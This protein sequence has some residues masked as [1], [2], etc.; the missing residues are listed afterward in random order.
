M[1]RDVSLDVYRHGYMETSW[2][3]AQ[4]SAHKR[5]PRETGYTEK[6]EGNHSQDD[7]EER[8]KDLPNLLLELEL[9]A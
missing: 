1:L 5:R 9:L 7:E 6:Q 2:I 4:V 8:A 3:R